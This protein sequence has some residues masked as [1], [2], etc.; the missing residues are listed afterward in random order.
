ML[1]TNKFIC[2]GRNENNV[3]NNNELQGR[4]IS[5]HS[6]ITTLCSFLEKI[7]KGIIH[8]DINDYILVTVRGNP[9]RLGCTIPCVK[10]LKVIKKVG[11]KKICYVNEEGNLVICKVKDFNE[12]RAHRCR[13][14]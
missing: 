10:C 9:E 4:I 11:L 7:K 8:G 1:K 6:E 12:E 14:I 2:F 3:S 5:N 13:L